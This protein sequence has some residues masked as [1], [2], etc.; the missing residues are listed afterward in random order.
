MKNL[1]FL[2]FLSLSCCFKVLARNNISREQNKNS[3]S[4]SL[5]LPE[6]LRMINSA[7]GFRSVGVSP[8]NPGLI[9][10]NGQR[11]VRPQHRLDWQKNNQVNDNG[12]YFSLENTPVAICIPALSYQYGVIPNS[13]AKSW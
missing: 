11:G 2:L 5:P 8:L 3:Y 4:K 1:L 10:S 13:E 9:M 6:K 7:S 12:T